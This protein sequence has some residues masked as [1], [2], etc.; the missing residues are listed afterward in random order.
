MKGYFFAALIGTTVGVFAA[1]V[2]VLLF[3][4]SMFLMGV[5]K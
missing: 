4:W 3:K 1:T 2:I 5:C